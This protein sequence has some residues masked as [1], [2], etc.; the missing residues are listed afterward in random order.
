MEIKSSAF[1]R[2]AT[3]ALEILLS[4]QGQTKAAE[5]LGL[6][7]RL[8]EA[9]HN[10]DRYLEQWADAYSNGDVPTMDDI[11]ARVKKE[12]DE[13]VSRGPDGQLLPGSEP[14]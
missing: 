4:M 3:V 6:I 14:T 1:F 10:I 11:I 2:V 9:G 7:R 13:F 5:A 12:A 8:S